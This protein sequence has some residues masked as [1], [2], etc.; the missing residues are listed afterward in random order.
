[1]RYM[2]EPFEDPLTYLT[3]KESKEKEEPEIVKLSL[4][5]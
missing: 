2:G 3:P 5:M 1:M 4:V